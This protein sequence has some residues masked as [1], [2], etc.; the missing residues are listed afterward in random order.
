VK[1]SAF[2]LLALLAA[3][4]FGLGEETSFRTV[5]MPDAKG[6]PKKAILTFSDNDK[7]VEVR[8]AK[9]GDSVSIP[10]SQIDKCAYEYTTER[11]VVL[12]DAKNH[13]LEIDYHDQDARKVLVL[14]MEKKDYLRILDA[15][16][17]HTGMDVEILGN[18]DKRHEKIWH[19]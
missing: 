14:R 3:A 4:T 12:T 9:G 6:K 11:T 15:V 19:K 8:S 2:I 10:Y 17:A 7:A 16:K 18:A 5:R 1:K 13:W